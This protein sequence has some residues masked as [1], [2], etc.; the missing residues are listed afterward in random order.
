MIISLLFLSVCVCVRKGT[1][2]DSGRDWN[3]VFG[4]VTRWS[5]KL[6]EDVV[7]ETSESA[8]LTASRP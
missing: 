7:G 1:I 2:L 5:E 6:E 4:E 3:A 8:L